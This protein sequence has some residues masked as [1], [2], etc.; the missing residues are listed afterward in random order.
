[1]IFGLGAIFGGLVSAYLGS[2]FGRRKSLFVMAVPDVIGWFL[3]AGSNGV[4]M[5]LLGRFLN[6]LS[7]A[8]YSTSIQIYV[9]E[10]AQPHHRG[11]LSGITIPTLAVG[12]LF[13]YIM[14]MFMEWR[15]IAA[16]GGFI[17]LTHL[18]GI[19]RITKRKSPSGMRETLHLLLFM[20]EVNTLF[21][22]RIEFTIKESITRFT[23]RQYRKPFILLNILFLLMTFS[24]NHGISFYA[25]DILKTS[26]DALD[27][28]ISIVL[29]G[30]SFYL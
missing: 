30:E 22:F 26:H 15:Y 12:S 4:H 14:G 29:I 28:H 13:A 3:I 8:G 21:I 17:P 7:A 1:S 9:A 6:G 19:Y 11:W 2:H 5:I 16:V 27:E 23:R 18:I 24:G 10:I 20:I 25:L